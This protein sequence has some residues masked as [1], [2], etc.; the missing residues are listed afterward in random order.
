[1]LALLKQ[2]GA[3]ASILTL[4]S[5][6]PSDVTVHKLR[7]LLEQFNITVADDLLTV[8][9]KDLVNHEGSLLDALSRSNTI[10]LLIQSQLANIEANS[11]D[12]KPMMYC[13]H[14]GAL[15]VINPDE[16]LVL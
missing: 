13:R 12:G 4:L 14:C 15:N 5:S 1:M 16:V 6:K 8:V 7:V 11:K 9:V 2:K 3:L 10:A